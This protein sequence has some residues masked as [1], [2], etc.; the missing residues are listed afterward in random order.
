MRNLDFPGK[1]WIFTAILGK[2][3]YCSSK[4]T[5]FEHT[6]CVMIRY[7]NI[8]RPLHDPAAQNLGVATPQPLRIDAYDS[9]LA[10]LHRS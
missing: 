2:L 4:V 8:L 9:L 5:T 3:F 7:T 10:F 1:N 6:S